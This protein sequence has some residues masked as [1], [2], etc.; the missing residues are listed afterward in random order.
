VRGE[1]LDR[2]DRAAPVGLDELAGRWRGSTYPTGHPFDG[3]LEAYGWYG[4]E[5]LDPDRVHPLLFRNSAGAPRPLNPRLAPFQLVRRAPL[6][7]RLPGARLAFA[8]VRPLLSSRRPAARMRLLEYR[9]TTTAA[10]IY[11]ALPVID[12]FRRL[13]ERTLLGLMDMRG[14]TPPFFFTLRRDG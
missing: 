2:F 11:D 3:L 5:V 4:K 13:D 9:G 1:A 14:V 12:L 8:M 10:L 7:A 6:L